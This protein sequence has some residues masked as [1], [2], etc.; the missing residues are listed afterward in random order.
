MFMDLHGSVIC[1]LRPATFEGLLYT[2]LN[3]GQ[4]ASY[5]SPGVLLL[6]GP[7]AESFL[8]TSVDI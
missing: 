3:I 1:N 6:P 4:K 2:M 8:L 7:D 5:M